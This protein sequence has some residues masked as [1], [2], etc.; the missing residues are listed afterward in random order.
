VYLAGCSSGCVGDAELN[1]APVFCVLS[2]PTECDERVPVACD[3]I[4]PVCCGVKYWLAPVACGLTLSV[5]A[6]NGFSET[7]DEPV[8][9]GVMVGV[10]RLGS[11]KGLEEDGGWSDEAIRFEDRESTW[12]FFALVSS[13]YID[14]ARFVKRCA[15]RLWWEDRGAVVVKSKSV[16]CQV[17]ELYKWPS[18]TEAFVI[19]IR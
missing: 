9:W 15:M 3:V 4:A 16:S 1:D 14:P 2:A 18:I 6:R 17:L 10:V 5:G 7:P 19:Q 12:V 8:G 13:R 11:R